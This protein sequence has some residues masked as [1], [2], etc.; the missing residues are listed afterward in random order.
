MAYANRGTKRRCATC[1]AAFY[2]LNHDP[3]VC[4]KCHS[5]Y[6]AAPRL[7]TRGGRIRAHEPVVPETHEA[8]GFEEDE[9][10]EHT[11]EDEEDLAPEPM[12]PDDRDDEMRE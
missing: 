11:D 12:E 9:V 4:P 2:D 7:P 8:G 5:A 1:G 3:I 10:L 6:V